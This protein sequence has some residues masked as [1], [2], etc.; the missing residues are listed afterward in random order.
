M[1]TTP[2]RECAICHNAIEDLSDLET[3]E[4]GY[5]ALRQESQ[6]T[7]AIG[8]ELRPSFNPYLTYTYIH[9]RCLVPYEAKLTAYNR[10]TVLSWKTRQLEADNERIRTELE[11]ICQAVREMDEDVYFNVIEEPALQERSRQIIE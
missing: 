11:R 9:L 8:Y 10:V 5:T 4:L 6:L 7:S 1:A 2:G 3:L